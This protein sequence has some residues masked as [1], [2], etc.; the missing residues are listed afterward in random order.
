MVVPH[1]ER[2]YYD[3][4]P[5]YCHPEAASRERGRGARSRWLLRAASSDVSA[6]TLLGFQAT[7]NR[8]RVWLAR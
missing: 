5:V 1:G 3:L 2:S 4:R 7:S 8:S 6:Q